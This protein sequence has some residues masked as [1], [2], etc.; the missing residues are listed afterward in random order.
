MA[1]VFSVVVDSA[2]TREALERLA[3]VGGDMRAV[4]KA[5]SVALLSATE[6]NFA[7]EGRPAWP[8]LA[9]ST[10]KARA[11]KGKWPGKMLQ[12]TGQLAASVGTEATGT[13]AM[14]GAGKVYAAT[15]QF[16][17]GDIPARPFL[18]IVG[19]QLQPQAEEEVLGIIVSHFER[20]LD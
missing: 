20:A 10:M 5:I 6:D 18:P 9:A 12:V 16:G 3:A 19:D 1:D 4:N 13:Y 17:R 7:A 11:R 2:A 15:H 8:M 14:V